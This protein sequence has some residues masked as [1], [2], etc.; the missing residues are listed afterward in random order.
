MK[1]FIIDAPVRDLIKMVIFLP[2]ILLDVIKEELFWWL[3]LYPYEI[4]YPTNWEKHCEKGLAESRHRIMRHQRAQ[5][6]N[7]RG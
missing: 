6:R 1:I 4:S 7:L 3:I 2:K 5:N